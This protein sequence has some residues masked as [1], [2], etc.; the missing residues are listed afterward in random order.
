MKLKLLKKKNYLSIIENSAKGENLMFR[1]LWAEKNENTID[2]VENGRL[3][4]AVFVSTVLYLFKAI[5]DL[6]ATVEATVK[7]M[8]ESG[9]VETKD[10]EP[11]VVLV[12]EK[13]DFGSN[14]VHSHIG[15]YTG[16]EEAVSNSSMDRGVP[17]R[18]HYTYNNTRKIE[19]I[20]KYP[21]F[22]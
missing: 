20:L 15:F 17:I 3:S 13:K 21:E 2:I 16:D 9:W 8:L 10:F 6:H 14:G 22:N 4:C 11:G 7:D 12:W 19:K 5:G 18:H 1:N